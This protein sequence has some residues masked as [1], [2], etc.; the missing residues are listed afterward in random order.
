[1]NTVVAPRGAVNVLCDRHGEPVVSRDLRDDGAAQPVKGHGA[2]FISKEGNRYNRSDQ[3]TVYCAEDAL[4]ALT[5]GAF[6]QALTW[7]EEIA[8]SRLKA[9]TYPLRSEHLLWA[10]RLDPGPVLLDLEDSHARARFG[11]SPHFLLNPSRAYAGTQ[12][13]A[14]EVRGYVPPPSAPHSRPEGMKAPSVRTPRSGAFQPSQF[15]LFVRDIPGCPP[16]EHRATLAAKMR[17]EIEFLESGAEQSCGELRQRRDRLGS[18]AV[19]PLCGPRRTAAFA[20][21]C[22]RRAPR[23]EKLPRE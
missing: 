23:G 9:L 20:D 18:A 10:F 1:V 21:S 12:A 3:L 16:Y 4:V 22:L 7:H 13:L 11:F 6:Y 15:I 14:D 17:L 2:Y 19:S 5:E 8:S